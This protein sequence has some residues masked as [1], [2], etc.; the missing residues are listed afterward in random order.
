MRRGIARLERTI[1]ESAAFDTS[2]LTERWSNE[3]KALEASID[4]ALSSAFGH[5]TIEYKRYALATS[6]NGIP[7]TIPLGFYGSNAAQVAIE[8][9]QSV[10]DGVQRSTLLLQ[11]AIRWLGVR[12]T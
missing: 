5:G 2:T 12:R 10:I 9:R 3:Q 8:A 6:L 7:A 11:Q 4:G 1:K